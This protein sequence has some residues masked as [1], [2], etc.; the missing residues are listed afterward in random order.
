MADPEL[1]HGFVYN[2]QGQ[3][4]TLKSLFFDINLEIDSTVEDYV[5][6]IVFSLAAAIDQ[7]LSPIQWQKKHPLWRKLAPAIGEKVILAL[8]MMQLLVVP[9]LLCKNLVYVLFCDRSLLVP[10]GARRT[11]FF[12]VADFV[13]KPTEFLVLSSPAAWFYKRKAKKPWP[14][15]QGPLYAHT[16]ELLHVGR[17][18]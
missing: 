8:D 14:V 16:K 17:G 9:D 13:I 11:L 10:D 18:P 6:M 1:D 15:M 7:Q 12:S 3:V 4:D 2:D 5:D